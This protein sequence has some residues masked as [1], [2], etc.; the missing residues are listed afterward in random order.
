EV[1]FLILKSYHASTTV[2]KD[3]T[4][5]T[6]IDVDPRD[7]D[8][9]IVDDI[10]DTGKSFDFVDRHL[11]MQHPASVTGFALLA[12]PDRHEVVYRPNY[13]GFSVPDVWV[14]GYG[15]D[16]AEK[17]RGNPDIIVKHE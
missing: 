8:V 3:I 9:L 14:E 15:M 6:D 7:R 5:V 4:L 11:K 1:S 17:G 10:F 12:K 13:I 16:S 2:A